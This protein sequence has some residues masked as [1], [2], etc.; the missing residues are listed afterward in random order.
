MYTV[1]SLKFLHRQNPVHER[2]KK[3]P[4]D[5]TE[6]WQLMHE[7]SLSRKS[8]D[9]VHQYVDFYVQRERKKHNVVDLEEEGI[10][11][12]D[13]DDDEKDSYS[14]ADGRCK[15][16]KRYPTY[17]RINRHLRK[18]CERASDGDERTATFTVPAEYRGE[19]LAE[20]KKTFTWTCI[21][22]L[23]VEVNLFI[24]Q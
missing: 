7:L 6:A 12:E 21:V 15:P 22:T 19:G 20:V 24:Y 2:I 10:F 13:D 8:L 1:A 3:E 5:L 23:L 11:S 9:K 18:A 17:K 4:K 14:Y 16:K